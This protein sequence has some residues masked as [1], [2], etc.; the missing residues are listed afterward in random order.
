MEWEIT[1]ASARLGS[2]SESSRA[3]SSSASSPSSMMV[4]RVDSDD[5]A[6]GEG[7]EKLK[8]SSG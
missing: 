3:I 1:Y 5:R 2:I 6:A 8:N 4:T 7:E